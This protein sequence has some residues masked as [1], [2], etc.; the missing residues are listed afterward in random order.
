[1]T[2]VRRNLVTDNQGDGFGVNGKDHHSLLKGDVATRSG[3]DG[4]DIESRTA[5]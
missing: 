1:M 5:D 4:F 3:D 2:D